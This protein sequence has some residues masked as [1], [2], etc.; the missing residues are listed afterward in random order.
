V[1]LSLARLFNFSFSAEAK[2]IPV[3]EV[4]KFMVCLENENVCLAFDIY[5]R[6]YEVVEDD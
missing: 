4:Q 6:C 5:G 2:A 1:C 3:E